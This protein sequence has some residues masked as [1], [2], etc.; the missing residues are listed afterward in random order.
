MAAA[1]ISLPLPFSLTLI[2]LMPLLMLLLP[3]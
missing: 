2:P 1:D 3:R